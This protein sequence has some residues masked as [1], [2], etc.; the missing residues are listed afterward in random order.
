LNF[1]LDRGESSD[2]KS[3]SELVL[4]SAELN[5]IKKLS[6]SQ[7]ISNYTF[8]LNFDNHQN[9]NGYTSYFNLVVKELSTGDYYSYIQEFRVDN[10]LLLSNSL[11]TNMHHYNGFMVFYNTVGE[12]LITIELNN[13]NVVNKEETDKCD[14]GDGEGSSSGGGGGSAEGSGPPGGSGGSGSGGEFIGG[15]S[16]SGWLCNWRGSFHSNPSD[17][18]EPSEGGTWIFSIKSLLPEGKGTNLLKN[19]CLPL[20]EECFSDVQDPC[21]CDGNGGCVI[22]NDEVPVNFPINI[23]LVSELNSLLDQNLT[24][25]QIDALAPY[26]N[27]FF[28]SMI[29]FLNA[30]YTPE[31]QGF[32]EEVIE[33]LAENPVAEVDFDPS[34]YPGI[35]EGHP[36]MWW[37][38]NEYINNNFTIFEPLPNAYEVLLF[39]IFPAAAL[40]H[41]ENTMEAMSR[42]EELCLN[43]TLCNGDFS[44]L[45]DGKADAFRHSYW[46]ALGTAVFSDSI[47]KLFAD[48]HEW[49]QDSLSVEMDL[50]NN[51]IG[52]N[53]GLNFSFSDSNELIEFFVLEALN[54]GELRYI[55]NGALIPT[56]L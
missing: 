31:A 39:S 30:N 26:G 27:E 16:S 7:G 48:A 50:F 17:C 9:L 22:E 49:G 34:N 45:E 33:V 5:N 29:D 38:D 13:G 53:I 47:M 25:E 46:N 35:D 20:P 52:R 54:N 32:I 44:G 28:Q 24:P 42:A 1:L 14:S 21:E 51:E 10:T 40:A 3:S 43:D 18:N 15:G 6:N 41:I 19:G 2:N 36:F 8:Q 12:F 56:N 23:A 55:D 4:T 11:Q 37:Q